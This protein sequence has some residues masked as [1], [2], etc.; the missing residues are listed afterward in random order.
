MIIV[1]N[2]ISQIT[3]FRLDLVFLIFLIQKLYYNKLNIYMIL[4][5]LDLDSTQ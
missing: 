3:I 5:E 2:F 4:Y 1:S